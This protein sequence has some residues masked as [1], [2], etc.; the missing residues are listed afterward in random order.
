MRNKIVLRQNFHWAGF[1]PKADIFTVASITVI[2]F[3]GVLVRF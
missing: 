2:L 1:A 3:S